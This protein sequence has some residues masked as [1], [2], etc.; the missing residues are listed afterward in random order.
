MDRKWRVAIDDLEAYKHSGDL[1]WTAWRGSKVRELNINNVQVERNGL[2]ASDMPIWANV[3]VLPKSDDLYCWIQHYKADI[4]TDQLR[5]FS[6]MRSHCQKIRRLW[7][8]QSPHHAV[9]LYTS[10]N[11]ALFVYVSIIIIY[12]VERTVNI[13]IQPTISPYTSNR[14]YHPNYVL[15]LSTYTPEHRYCTD[16]YHLHA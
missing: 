1:K 13:L 11:I 5:Q 2:M 6:Q 15:T 16:T 7:H 14:V 3:S 12:G 9:D 4:N 10:S 8:N